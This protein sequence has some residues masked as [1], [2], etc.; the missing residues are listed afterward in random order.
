[1]AF[2]AGPSFSLQVFN[3][4][5]HISSPVSQHKEVT[6]VDEQLDIVIVNLV[7]TVGAPSS[8]G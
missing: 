5:F 1:M 6:E 4:S 8:F 7:K 2:S 3:D